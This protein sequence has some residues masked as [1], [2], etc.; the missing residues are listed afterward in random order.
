MLA[1][2]LHFVW[3][4]AAMNN[5]ILLEGCHSNKFSYIYILGVNNRVWMDKLYVQK[6]VQNGY[7][8]LLLYMDWCTE[9]KFLNSN[10]EWKYLSHLETLKG[11]KSYFV[12]SSDSKWSLVTV[13]ILLVVTK[14]RTRY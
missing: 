7:F 6:I 10:K 13:E 4:I 3:N 11:I 12:F 5:V 9:K 2:S 1:C 8:N 14:S